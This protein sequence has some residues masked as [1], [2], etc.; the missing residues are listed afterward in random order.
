[1][2]WLNGVTNPDITS[3]IQLIP[4]WWQIGQKIGTMG[5]TPLPKAVCPVL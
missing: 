3:P 1:M 4:L 2:G 5:T